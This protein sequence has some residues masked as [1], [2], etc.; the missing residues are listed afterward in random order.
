MRLQ[1]KTHEIGLDK[2]A[3]GLICKPWR[4]TYVLEL[5][6]RCEDLRLGKSRNRA[7]IRWA[8][9]KAAKARVRVRA[10][11][12]KGELR[13]WYELYLHTMRRNVVPPRPYRFFEFLWNSMRRTGLMELLL[14]EQCG[15]TGEKL[16]AG[17]IFLMFGQ[18]VSYTFNG[19]RRED[20][21]L[22]P[23]DAILSFAIQ[24]AC[25]AGFRRFDFGEVPEGHARLAE[26]KSKW[27]SE[28]TRLVRYYYPAS[29]E[30]VSEQSDGYIY[31]LAE[32]VWQRLP[33]RTTAVLGD[34]IYGHL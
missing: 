12:T 25:Q 23:N 10:A 4:L 19:A 24:K 17:S 9:N 16:V 31:H 6:S 26:F 33:L 27:G 11:E 20:F 34:W 28:A 22:H 29:S 5:P 8:V 2:L 30:S 13:V 7:R 32:A 21:S 14:A 15:N 3:E 1:I 18:T